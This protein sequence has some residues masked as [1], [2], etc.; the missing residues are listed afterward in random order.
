MIRNI[1]AG[2]G[3][4]IAANNYSTP[5]IDMSR[6]SAGMVRYNGSGMEVYDGSVWVALSSSIPQ[7]ELDGVTQEAVQWVRR[8]MEE[9][10]QLLELAKTHPTVADALLARDRAED[11]VKIAAALCKV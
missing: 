11:A 8:K 2:L 6:H 5:Y 4:Y 9:E 7:I 1:T 3:L 10:K